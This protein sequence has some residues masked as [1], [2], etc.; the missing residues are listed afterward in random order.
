MLAL[1]A[2]SPV[3]V[4]N[5][6]PVAATSCR[7]LRIALRL[8]DA[9]AARKS[10]K[11][12]YPLVGATDIGSRAG[13]ANRPARIRRAVLGVEGRW[14]GLDDA[15]P[16]VRPRLPAR[17]S[18]VAAT[19]LVESAPGRTRRRGPVAGVNGTETCSLG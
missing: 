5:S 4:S 6:T 1:D 3:S 17:R 11:L 9:S 14:R 7:S 13:S 18:G 8:R 2:A 19:L 15:L 16:L 10:S 12:P